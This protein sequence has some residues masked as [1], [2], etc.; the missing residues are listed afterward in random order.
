MGISTDYQTTQNLTVGFLRFL[1]SWRSTR[2]GLYG[3]NFL[4]GKEMNRAGSLSYSIHG[5]GSLMV[6]TGSSTF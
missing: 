2:E 4:K 3:T 5:G 1:E 6:I